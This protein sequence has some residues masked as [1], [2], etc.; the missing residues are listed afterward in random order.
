MNEI[1]KK[2]EASHGI[3]KN[4]DKF[5]KMWSKGELSFFCKRPIDPEY[6]DYCIRD[7]LD[8][9][10][11]Y[12]KML[13]RLDAKTENIAYWVSKEYAKQGYETIIDEDK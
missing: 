12:E 13:S 1:F 7:V 10:E 3:N 2:Y 8:L 9:P 6:R 4:K 11:V 5:H